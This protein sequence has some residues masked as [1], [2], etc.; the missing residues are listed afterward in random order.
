MSAWESQC[1]KTSGYTHHLPHLEGLISCMVQTEW[2]QGTDCQSI[3]E[4][5]NMPSIDGLGKRN[6]FQSDQTTERI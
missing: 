5:I 1:L 4:D 6:G 2:P 3:E